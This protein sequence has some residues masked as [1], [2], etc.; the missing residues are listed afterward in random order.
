LK[1]AVF[2]GTFNPVHLGHLA[3]AK[4]VLGSTEYERILFIPANIRPNKDYED[5]GVELRL[6]MLSGAIA[7]EPRFAISD[8]EIRRSGISY[9]IDTIRYLVGSGLVEACPGLIIGDDLVEGFHTW[10]EP[11]G[12]LAECRIVI[13]RRLPEGRVVVP[14]EHVYIDNE[15]IAVSSSL[16]RNLIA[17]GEAWEQ[18]V[19][20][21]AR[22]TIEK[23]G[24]YGFRNNRG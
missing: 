5:P 15:V 4:A 10:K 13:A 11:E 12:L 1:T 2:G 18:L 9:S 8:C 3:I 24:L 17:R 23:F 7:G 22:E 21:S 14:F 16:V 6:R 19:P 20:G